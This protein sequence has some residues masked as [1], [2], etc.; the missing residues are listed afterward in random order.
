[1]LLSAEAS[2]ILA[3]TNHSTLGAELRKEIKLDGFVPSLYSTNWSIMLYYD[4]TG[5]LRFHTYSHSNTSYSSSV[6]A[7]HRE[8]ERDIEYVSCKYRWESRRPVLHRD[9][10]AAHEVCHVGLGL[11]HPHALPAADTHTSSSSS[12]SS[13]SFSLMNACTSL[14]SYLNTIICSHH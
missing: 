2:M 8:T 10:Q 5:W 3:V 13:F 12:S 11:W 14:I 7:R 4:I 9:H 6:A 1:M